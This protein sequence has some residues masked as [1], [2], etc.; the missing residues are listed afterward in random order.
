MNDQARRANPIR[1]GQRCLFERRVTVLCFV[2]A[3]S[4]VGAGCESRPAVN[5]A[6][7]PEH[8]SPQEELDPAL[9][10]GFKNVYQDDDGQ[11]LLTGLPGPSGLKAAADHGV[12]VVVDLLT[13]EE[14][15]GRDEAARVTALGMDYVHIPV[16]PASFSPADV[17]RF[18]EVMEG[19]GGVVLVHCASANRSGGLWAAYLNR[20]RGVPLEQAVAIG[21][22]TGLRRDS[23]IDAVRRVA[24]SDPSGE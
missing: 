2:A 3:L 19:A 23:M 24:A 22:S 1:A 17:D 9:A 4:L 12:V 20:Y 14:S 8:R 13:D 15:V 5:E 21:R 6:A 16:S 18:A 11:V 10:A 7:A